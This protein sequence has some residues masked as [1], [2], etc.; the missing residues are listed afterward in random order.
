V[1]RKFFTF[2]LDGIVRSQLL[3]RRLNMASISKGNSKIKERLDCLGG[4]DSSMEDRS[5]MWLKNKKE[6]RETGKKIYFYR[7]S[8]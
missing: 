5:R 7:K 8:Y 1:K 3:W 6:E 2:A 4:F